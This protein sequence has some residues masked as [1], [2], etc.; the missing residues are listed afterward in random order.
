[1][2]KKHYYFASLV[3]LLVPLAGIGTDIYLPSLPSMVHVFGVDR[4]Y[5][6]LTVT[7]YV[8]A[9][10]IAQLL[11]GPMSDSLGRKKLI[12]ASLVFQ[13]LAIFI[14]LHVHSII[15]VIAGRFVQGFA[16]A[17]MI[18]P[19]RA[20]L[21]DVFSGQQLKKHFNYLT[22]SFALGPIV[23]PF[24]GGY[25]EH[26][27]GWYASFWFLFV[28][29]LIM[30]VAVLFTLPE[31]LKEQKRFKVTSMLHN[32][33]MVFASMR[34]K[35]FILFTIFLYAYTAIFSVIGPFIFQVN[36]HFNAVVYGYIALGV[37]VC[38]FS[39]NMT[40]RFLFD[41][42]PHKKISVAL[43]VGSLVTVMMVIFAAQGYFNVYLAALPIYGL[44][45]LS[46]MVF[47]IFVGECLSLFPQIPA[48]ANA[49]FFSLSWFGFAFFT[50]VAT[51]LRAHTL[52]P[53]AV[54]FLIVNLCAQLLYR[55]QVKSHLH[56]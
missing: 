15:A 6:Q 20:I 38:W 27:I 33:Q 37:G 48:S 12:V 43:S 30:L 14:I 18:V 25:A 41:V 54:T 29:A 24:I 21:N 46:G 4:S 8:L 5:I 32:Y 31:T 51:L 23:A 36:L 39:G 11:A 56:E 1:M 7:A 19:A 26:Y 9:M 16:A 10:G 44:I 3:Y 42:H 40:N 55:S 35:M 53:I 17:F 28:C 45:F 22:I 50:G 47:P 49:C 34:Y 52:L 13:L 2:P